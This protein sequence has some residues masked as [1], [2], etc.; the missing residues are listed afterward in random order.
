MKKVKLFL[1]LSIII[2]ISSCDDY[3]KKVKSGHIET[4]YKDGITEAQA[5]R[6]A[7]LLYNMDINAGNEATEKSFQLGKKNDTV[8]LKMV[9][10][11]PNSTDVNDFNFMAV[12][13]YISD[14]AF[15]GAPVNMDLSDKYF[16][17]LRI[18]PY[19][20]LTEQDIQNAK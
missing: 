3:G 5:Q 6:T 16:K 14:S 11:S 17:T 8:Y 12:G 15:N 20:K 7:T 10:A 19:K 9:V 2:S 13:D 18:I 4:F 1:F